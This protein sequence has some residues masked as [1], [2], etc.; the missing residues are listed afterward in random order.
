MD[1]TCESQDAPS[2][3]STFTATECSRMEPTTSPLIHIIRH[4]QA[5]H[6]VDRSYPYRDPPLTDAGHEATQQIKIPAVPDLIVIS[7]MTR[8]IQT[9]MNAFPS[10]ASAPNETKVQIWPDLREA[11]DA[12]CNK[13]ISRA[14]IS[15]KFPD[16]NFSECP[17]E[18]DH[19][20]HTIEG[21]TI[22]AETVRRRLKEL[23]KEYNNI[24]LITHRG[25]I[26]F[27]VKGDR[28][29]VCESRSYQFGIDEEAEVDALRF[30]VNRD[31]MLRQDFGPTVLVPY[32]PQVRIPH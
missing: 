19:P 16:L 14:E 4:G 15:T 29:D 30:G 18:W 28:Y 20:P 21:A 9:A 2:Y 11:H 12:I 7:P 3:E 22:R 27:L 6:N 17:E 23:S 24:V 10:I 32:T 5:L 31:T 13:G 26:A 25:F 8:T 1:P